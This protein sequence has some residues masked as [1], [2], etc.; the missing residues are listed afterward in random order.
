[1]VWNG[2]DSTLRVTTYHDRVSARQALAGELREAANRFFRGATGKCVDF[3][4]VD[5]EDDTY[6]F[7]FFAPA[8]TAGYGKRY[9]QEI[10]TSGRV[11]REYKE[12]LGPTGVLEIKWVHGGPP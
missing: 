2:R 3:Q 8:R 5:L 6:R 12:T 4:V 10:D 9:V 11:L 1:M 7:E